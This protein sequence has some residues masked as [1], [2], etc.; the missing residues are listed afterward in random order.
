MAERVGTASIDLDPARLDRR[1]LSTLEAFVDQATAMV[2]SDPGTA[3]D[4]LRA[5]HAAAVRRSA[6]EL[7]ARCDYAAARAAV[8]LGHLDQALDLIERARAEFLSAHAEVDAARTDLGRMHVLD[9]LGRHVDAIAVG[10]ELLAKLPLLARAPGDGAALGR[11]EAAGSE[12]LGVS[13]GYLGHHREAIAAYAVAER[14]YE[15]LGLIEDANRCRANRGVELVE[16]GELD[17]ALPVLGEARAG[18]LD[19]NDRLAAA[20]CSAYEASGHLGRGDYVLALRC[21]A[22]SEDLLRGQETTTEYARVQLVRARTLASLNLVD[23]AL[24][25]YGA[26]AARFEAAGLVRDRATALAD[27]ATLLLRS[28]REHDAV[29]D[30]ET[31][32]ELFDEIGDDAMRAVADVGRSF[33]PDAVD[34][35]GLVTRSVETL[36]ALGRRPD[37]IAALLRL[38][39]LAPPAGVDELLTRCER[40]L[41]GPRLPHLEW[42]VRRERARVHRRRGDLAAAESELERAALVVEELRLTVADERGRIPFLGTRRAVHEDRIDLVLER[43]DVERAYALTGAARARTLGERHAITHGHTDELAVPPRPSSGE[44]ELTYEILG[45]EV[46]AFVRTADD[47]SVVR[48]VTTARTV[49]RLVDRLDAHWRRC[50]DRGLVARHEQR[51]VATAVDVM[52]QLHLALL[53]PI[54]EVFDASMLTVVPVGPVSNVPFAAL[55]D[56]TC[57]LVERCPIGY[58]ASVPVAVR[59]G[60]RRRA[61]ERMLLVGCSDQVAPR[62]ADEVEAIARWR[63]GSTMLTDRAATVEAVARAITRHDVAHIACHGVNRRDNPELSALHL[64]DGPWTAIEIAELELDGQ[65]VVL[66]ACSSGRQQTIGNADEAVG[67]PRAFLAAGAS[68]VVVNLW[69]VDDL[70]ALELMTDLHTRLDRQSP[71]AA[72]REA[73]LALLSRRAHPYLWAPTVVY[74]GLHRTAPDHHPGVTS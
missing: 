69:Q 64:V 70:A 17:E 2:P 61:G 35:G 50:A 31:A 22:V 8:S 16:L 6:P 59:A 27:R 11:L 3:V 18:F 26:L 60:A 58:A 33:A 53:G 74:A 47:L 38:V 9:D 13:H 32:S 7:A 15:D 71:A 46:I 54:P 65:L 24:A 63:L 42:Q 41:A 34:A 12:N 25:L 55:H 21:A 5:L 23:D 19:A 10:R 30:F 73:Q 39:E 72:L 43:G 36:A 20:L 56:G 40:R 37:E 49:Q 29:V 44:L 68:D 51:L 45:D 48:R 57:H 4:A 14:R 67:L 66:S 62:V 52:Q 1:S 28:D